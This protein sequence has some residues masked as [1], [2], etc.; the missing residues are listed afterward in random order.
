MCGRFAFFSDNKTLEK[1]FHA[2]I[3]KLLPRHYNAAPTQQLPL[4]TNTEP[5]IIQ[6]GRWGFKPSWLKQKPTGLINARKETLVE[7]P[8]FLQ[9]FQKRRCLV[10]SDGF[11]EWQRQGSSKQ[12]YYIHLKNNQPFAFAGIWELFKNKEGLLIP[13]FAII[14]AP[15]NDIITPL[16]D[17]MP[18]ILEQKNE[19]LWLSQ[20]S[21]L[22]RLTSLLNPVSA[23]Q[24]EVYPVSSAV[25]TIEIEN[26]DL[27]KPLQRL[28]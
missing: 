10:L 19:K 4:I 16:H 24:L 12:P 17:R 9:A 22:A 1:R 20:E 7:K 8:A 21:D 27:I 23:D 5:R 14:T 18:I 15:S 6:P 3:K 13:S 11:Y 26:P 2:K 28:L 25:N